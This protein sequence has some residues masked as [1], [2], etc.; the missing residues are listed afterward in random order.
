VC[1]LQFLLA[2]ASG[3]ILG[4][5]SWGIHDHILLSQIRHSHNL[6]SQ[7]HVF[8]YPKNRVAQA[9]GSIFVVPYDSQGYG[10]GI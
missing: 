6:E 5:E 1:R 2:F 7:I 4:A 3:V 8:V 9:L 10:G